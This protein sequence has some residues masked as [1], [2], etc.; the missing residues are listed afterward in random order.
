M[1]VTDH[2][3]HFGLYRKYRIERIDGS[4]G[5]GGKHEHC[6]YYTLDIDHDPFAVEAMQAY[7]AAC[8]AFYPQLAKDL[9][10]LIHACQ[11]KTAARRA[12]LMGNMSE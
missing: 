2:D 9:R 8:E 3:Q 4:S 6:R 1:H 7:A 12:Q 11:E 10:D 5:P